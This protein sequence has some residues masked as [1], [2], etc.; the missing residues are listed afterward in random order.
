MKDGQEEG[1]MSEGWRGG[2]GTTGRAGY[3]KGY[4]VT[5]LNAA[6]EKRQSNAG[7]KNTSV[8][9]TFDIEGNPAAAGGTVTITKV[10]PPAPQPGG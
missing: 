7:R 4:I 1:K 9:A 6:R 10:T 2:S 8:V 3:G 5:Y